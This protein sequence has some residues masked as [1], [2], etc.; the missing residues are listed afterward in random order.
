MDSQVDLGP[1]T[2]VFQEGLPANKL[3][4]VKTGEVLCLKS[5]RDR[6]I[7]IFL[8]KA[9]DIIGES[10]MVKEL[11]YTYTAITFSHS[12]LISVTAE[13][14]KEVFEKAPTWLTELTTTM[15]S[16]YQSSANLLA[17]N[18]MF[19]QSI[20]SEELFPS[21]LEIEFKRLLSKTE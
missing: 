9:G 16:R 15:I 2:L 19:H 3:Y 1:R 4:L 21:E 20:L 13:S 17:E 6:L 10:A 8:A 12:E 5:S 14:F 7:P 11:D 18:R